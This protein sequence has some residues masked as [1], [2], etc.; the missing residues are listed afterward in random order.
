MRTWLQPT[1]HAHLLLRLLL[2]NLQLLPENFIFYFFCFFFIFFSSK[3]KK[4]KKRENPLFFSP[5]LCYCHWKSSVPLILLILQLLKP[6]AI[7][8]NPSLST[9]PS[10]P[11]LLVVQKSKCVFSINHIFLAIYSPNS[12]GPKIARQ[13]HEA[14][15]LVHRKSKF[16]NRFPE[17]TSLGI[18][19]SYSELQLGQG[20]SCKP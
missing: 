2:S 14:T 11:L 3:K 6:F 1:R 20:Y 10:E 13:F 7:S 15:F 5:P 12:L 18:L 19:K 9:T 4:K 16:V 8:I 17:V